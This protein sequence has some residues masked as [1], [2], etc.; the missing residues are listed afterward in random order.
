VEL[1]AQGSLFCAFLMGV[2][3]ENHGHVFI[4]F[5]GVWLTLVSRLCF[6]PFHISQYTLS[7][8]TNDEYVDNGGYVDVALGGHYITVNGTPY[9]TPELD[10]FVE[11]LPDWTTSLA[12]PATYDAW[13]VW[14]SLFLES[15]PIA[16]SINLVVLSTCIRFCILVFVLAAVVIC[17]LFSANWVSSCSHVDFPF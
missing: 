15:I 14:W 13:I 6:H 5:R 7:L 3:V 8:Q 1:W 10:D 16:A 2:S 11:S 4:A 12:W 17:W 9:M